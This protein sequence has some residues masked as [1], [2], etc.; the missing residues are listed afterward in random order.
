MRTSQT[1]Q[2]DFYIMKNHNVTA[3]F[4][5]PDPLTVGGRGKKK[6]KHVA[7]KTYD[8]SDL[9]KQENF[10]VRLSFRG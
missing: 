7:F 10:S 4:L 1:L 8:F 2:R 9:M 3:Y 5:K 6:T